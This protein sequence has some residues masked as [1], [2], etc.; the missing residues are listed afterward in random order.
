M[1]HGNLATS[2]GIMFA[3]TNF[4]AHAKNMQMN[5]YHLVLMIVLL[6]KNENQGKL[7]D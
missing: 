4:F 5:R 3:I 1:M 7:R 6:V 2:L